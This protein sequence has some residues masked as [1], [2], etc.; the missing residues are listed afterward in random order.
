MISIVMSV[1]N[2]E[3]FISK[4]IESVLN[5]TY[6]NFEFIILDD[7][8]FDNSLNIIQEYSKRDSRIRIISKKNTGLTKSLNIGLNLACGQYIARIDSDDVW[9][10]SKL[11]KQVQFLESYSNYA[12]IG[13]AYNEIDE[14]DIIIK[15]NQTVLLTTTDSQIKERIVYCNPFLHSAVL[16][17]TEVLQSIGG[18]NEDFK[19]TQDYELWI[20]I[21][22]KYKVA[23]LSDILVSRRF[24][25]NM[26][27]VKQEK[28]QR[29]FA[30][31]AKILA[32]K[33]LKKDILSYKHLINDLFVY[34][35]PS[36]VTAFIRK[37]NVYK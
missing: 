19:Y 16:F 11:A 26:I 23:N 30:L 32:I 27:S 2:G 9:E 15:H 22:S 1:Y 28:E 37:L 31:K 34:L 13:S 14:N 35:L 36:I 20:R 18:Y 12:L 29:F 10:K 8:S 3:K 6:S 33:L 25:K 5:Q 24:S 21:M 7:G 4:A 17:R